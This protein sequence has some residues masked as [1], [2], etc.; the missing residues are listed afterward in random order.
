MKRA[1][2]VGNG[3]A[4]RTKIAFPVREGKSWPA[5]ILAT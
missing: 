5:D 4:A 3:L 1:T 2:R